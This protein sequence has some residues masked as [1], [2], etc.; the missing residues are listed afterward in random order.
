MPDDLTQD[1][2]RPSTEGQANAELPP[3]LR[4]TFSEHTVDADGGKCQRDGSEDTHENTHD[5]DDG[6]GIR[7]FPFQCGQFVDGNLGIELAHDFTQRTSIILR[8]RPGTQQKSHA[9][10]GVLQKRLV[11]DWATWRIPPIFPDIADDPNDGE[12]GPVG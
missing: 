6:N 7:D 10:L 1:V 2:R 3:A 8:A 4:H 11:D 12:P 5:A 9:A